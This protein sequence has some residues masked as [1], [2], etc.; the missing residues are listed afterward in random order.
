MILRSM[1]HPACTNH[2]QETVIGLIR[3]E[4]RQLLQPNSYQMKNV[5]G[6]S[7]PATHEEEEH[8]NT[9]NMKTLQCDKI[10]IRMRN[11]ISEVRVKYCT[12]KRMIDGEK[13]NNM[14]VSK[15]TRHHMQKLSI[16]RH[17]QQTIELDQIKCKWNSW[18]KSKL[19]K[20][21]GKQL[22][23]KASFYTFN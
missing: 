1:K 9:G 3:T 6:G 4:S 22:S 7:A 12:C 5:K 14:I 13:E 23:R 21:I 11:T 20:K 8:I 15:S 19:V 2:H 16:R 17:M 18:S 10:K